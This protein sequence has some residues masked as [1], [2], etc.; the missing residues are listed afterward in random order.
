MMRHPFLTS[1]TVG[2]DAFVQSWLI[3]YRISG[4]YILA[5][6]KI[7]P[8]NTWSGLTSAGMVSSS[9]LRYEVAAVLVIA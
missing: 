7:H 3:A 1:V 9:A 2:F 4:Q 5:M 6:N 8:T